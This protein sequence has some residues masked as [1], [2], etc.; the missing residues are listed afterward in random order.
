MGEYSYTIGISRKWFGFKK[1]KNVVDNWYE[2]TANNAVFPLRLVIKFSDGS[3]ISIGGI[4][5]QTVKVYPD[6]HEAR[7]KAVQ[8]R[9]EEE[10]AKQKE[11]GP[12]VD[13]QQSI[14][15]LARQRGLI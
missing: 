13:D 14:H 9:I 3:E 1:Y 6:Y 12:P 11:M 7:E 8:D 10:K 2:N 4:D 5:N 15:E